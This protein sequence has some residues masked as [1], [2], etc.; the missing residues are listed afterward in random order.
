MAGISPPGASAPSKE[1]GCCS[2]F[3]RSRGRKNPA[4]KTHTPGVR[5]QP[6]PDPIAST[7]QKAGPNGETKTNDPE[8]QKTISEV[9]VRAPEELVAKS[10]Q[11]RIAEK[12]FE[13]AAA[14][15]ENALPQQATKLRIPE[16]LSLQNVDRVN[17]VEETAKQLES[18]IDALIDAR[19]E[20]SAIP[21]RRRAVKDCVSRW[22][23][24]SFPYIKSS[25]S[26]V[27]VY[28]ASS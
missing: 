11:R 21:S 28:G 13:T 8:P 4:D 7:Q 2:F 14:N 19:T 10:R 1:A 23:N 18:A 12:N 25:L 26:A 24:A 9:I 16:E 3:R 15:L 5:V 22:F 27:G 6:N 17:N 20:L